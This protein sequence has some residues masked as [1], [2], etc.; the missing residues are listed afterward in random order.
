MTRTLLQLGRW[1]LLP[2]LA[3]A[4]CSG[5]DGST[6]PT[7]T[8]TTVAISPVNP[9]V[10]LGQTLQLKASPRDQR[11]ADMTATVTWSTAS[12]SVASVSASGLVTTI[13]A[14][15]ATV[16][17][18]ATAGERT[19]T[20]SVQVTVQQPP[21]LTSVVV[22][23]T[24]ATTVFLGSTSQLAASTLD[25]RGNPITASVSWTSSA[26]AVAS[27]GASGLVTGNLVGSATV[28]ASATAGGVT[29]ATAVPITVS[30]DA[31]LLSS[32]TVS[33]PST[34]VGTGE[35]LQLSANPRD[36]YGHAIVAN[37]AWSSSNPGAATVSATGLV[38][39]IAAGSVTITATGTAAGASVTG[40]SI[41]TVLPPF[42]QTAEVAATIN[43]T[44]V[45]GTVDIA[46]NGTVSWT[47][48]A[49]H[50]V[51]FSGVGAPGSIG[52]TSTGTV[53]LQFAN[54]GTFAYMC[55][56]HPGM[57]GTVV[58]H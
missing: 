53:S 44:F 27:V 11:S 16:I 10:V 38:A 57:S 37:V 13:G 55:T 1:R 15:V 40:T 41:L 17:A 6:G 19:V 25:Q 2:V 21:V 30:A 51:T 18:T 33:A 49:T 23:T 43:N 46:R 47:F 3:L 29:V 12:S 32:I 34:T 45:P 52:D 39:G 42:P 35:T 22:T 48:A 36:Q 4:A 56:I 54:V 8:L 9:S 20:N 26:S 24:T 14:G 5:G 28:T 50:N 58:V 31:P 7:H